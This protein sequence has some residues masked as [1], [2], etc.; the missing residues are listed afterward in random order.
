L[1][2]PT[3]GMDPHSRRMTWDIIRKYKSGRAIVLTT[4]FM[5]E[6]RASAARF[7]SPL[8]SDFFRANRTNRDSGDELTPPGLGLGSG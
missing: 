8:L 6:V 3:S 7:V 1:D 2:E 4:H 5:D